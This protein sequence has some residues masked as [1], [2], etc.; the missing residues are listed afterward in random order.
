MA[1]RSPAGNEPIQ[2]A[3]RLPVGDAA[4]HALATLYQRAQPV[5]LAGW[6]ARVPVAT[7]RVWLACLDGVVWHAEPDWRWAVDAVRLIRN[8]AIDWEALVETS[9]RSATIMPVREAL[10]FLALAL[11]APVPSATLGQLQMAAVS[12]AEARQFALISRR[13]GRL[14]AARRHWRQYTALAQDRPSLPG[15][16]RFLEADW[17]L[18]S[19]GEV[20][21]EVAKRGWMG[22]EPTYHF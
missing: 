19:S 5:T 20:L 8:A 1:F 7:D 22:V 3:W 10:G 15:F 2:I 13:Q 18:G 11:Q 17:A 14:G 16:V 21:R 4:G 9:R 6:G 12:A